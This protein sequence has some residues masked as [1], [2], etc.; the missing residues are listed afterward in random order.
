MA[1]KYIV[2]LDNLDVIAI[3]DKSGSMNTKDTPNGKSRWGYGIERI[4]SFVQ[5]VGEHDANGIDIIVFDEK[6]DE[7]LGVTP[8]SVQAVFQNYKPGNG[9]SMS[10]PLRHALEMASKRWNEKPQFIIVF[11]DGEPDDKDQVA[12]VII[13]YA[14]RMERD[15]QCAILF[16][17]VGKDRD[18]AKFLQALD[19]D[20]QSQGAKFDIVDVEPL[21]NFHNFTLQQ[22][23]DKAFND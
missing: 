12:R 15:E 18:A 10:G 2:N 9:T 8:D 13:E 21:E 23:V 5:E 6:F 14:N 4:D 1:E 20:L 11:T 7:S 19:D 22:I 17:Q 3:F 16:A